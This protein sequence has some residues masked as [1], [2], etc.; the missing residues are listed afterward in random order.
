MDLDLQGLSNYSE[1]QKVRG[2][3][4]GSLTL[5]LIRVSG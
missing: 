5:C 2:V 3:V 1:S 4:L